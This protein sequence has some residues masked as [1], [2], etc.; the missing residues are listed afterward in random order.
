VATMDT[1]VRRVLGR[2][3][4]AEV[5]AA[6]TDDRLAWRLAEAVLPAGDAYDWN[7]A[8][9][10]LGATVCVA[11]TPRCLLCPLQASCSARAAWSA[12]ALAPLPAPPDAAR[13]AAERP[14]TYAAGRSRRPLAASEPFVGSR[15]WY[16]GRIVAA[17]RALPPGA[18]LSLE[19]LGRQI[20]PDFALDDRPWL[21]DLAT[22]L[23]RDGLVALSEQQGEVSLGLPG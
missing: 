12:P 1:N 18:T 11:R 22:A 5:P 4:A 15:R 7:Q 9:M 23:A 14:A 17:L 16:R 3:F 2:V 8:L 10:D 19:A 21:L 13:L 20:K 6:A